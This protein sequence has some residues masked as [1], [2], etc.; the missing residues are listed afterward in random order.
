MKRGAILMK[1][2]VLGVIAVLGVYAAFWYLGQAARRRTGQAVGAFV[3]MSTGAMEEAAR[4]YEDV[5]YILN[6]DVAKKTFA[7]RLRDGSSALS[8]LPEAELGDFMQ[9]LAARPVKI[10]VSYGEKDF[11]GAAAVAEF[12]QRVREMLAPTGGEVFFVTLV[13][14]AS[15]LQ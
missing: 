10:A 4:R 12:E 3:D 5:N 6:Y 8:H 11:S 7:V 1:A 9:K 13:D 14:Q 2:L 15:L